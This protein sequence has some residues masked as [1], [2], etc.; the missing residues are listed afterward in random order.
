MDDIGY[1]HEVFQILF[2]QGNILFVKYENYKNIGHSILP[3]YN[4]F[5]IFRL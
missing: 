3:L 4:H 2:Q 5:G 1:V